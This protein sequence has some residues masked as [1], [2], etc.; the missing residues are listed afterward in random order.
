MTP[1][2][3]RLIDD[4]TLRGYAQRTIGAYVAVVARLSRFFHTAPDQLT[5]EQL[6]TYLVQLTTTRASATVTQVT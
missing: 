2:R 5:E 4:L 3:Q 1:L 6:R